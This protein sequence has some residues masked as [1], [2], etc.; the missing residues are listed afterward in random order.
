MNDHE[1]VARTIAIAHP[2][3]TCAA[4]INIIDELR[5]ELNSL[6]FANAHAEGLIPTNEAG[7]VLDADGEPITAPA[8]IDQLT[9][10]HARRNADGTPWRDEPPIAEV[11]PIGKTKGAGGST[12][13]R[14]R[15]RSEKD[16]DDG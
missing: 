1:D 11:V 13:K 14:K 4:L 16:S 8:L 6:R 2:G 12:G 9:R 7:I 15:R 5:R 3:G 10:L